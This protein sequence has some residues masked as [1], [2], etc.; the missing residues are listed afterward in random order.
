MEKNN[1]PSKQV[2]E[3]S[4]VA[5]FNGISFTI[6]Q[7][8]APLKNTTG[9]PDNLKSGIEHLSGIDISDVKVH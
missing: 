5:P 1:N 2:K 9:L 4:L 7:K 3:Q 8:Q 6:Q